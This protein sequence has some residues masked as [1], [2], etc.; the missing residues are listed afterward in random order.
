VAYRK[1]GPVLELRAL[2]GCFACRE[3]VRCL[4]TAAEGALILRL[5]RTAFPKAEGAAK[6]ALQKRHGDVVD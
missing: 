6:I 5:D 4:A 2:S 1:R 3:K